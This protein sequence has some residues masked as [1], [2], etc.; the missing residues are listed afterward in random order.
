[1]RDSWHPTEAQVGFQAA[2]RSIG[3]GKKSDLQLCL[4]VEGIH[5]LFDLFAE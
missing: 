4:G 1:V 3:L 2:R 5:L